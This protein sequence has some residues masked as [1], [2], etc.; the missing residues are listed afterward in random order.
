MRFERLLEWKAMHDWYTALWKNSLTLFESNAKSCNGCNEVTGYEMANSCSFERFSLV[1]QSPFDNWK[2]F[3]DN[4]LLREFGNLRCL[5]ARKSN[6]P[7]R[8]QKT[9]ELR[10]PNPLCFLFSFFLVSNFVPLYL[11]FPLVIHLFIYLFSNSSSL[12]PKP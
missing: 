3:F 12:L 6:T 7:D 1:I 11:Y 2:W 9:T 10:V 4:F 5:N 8:T